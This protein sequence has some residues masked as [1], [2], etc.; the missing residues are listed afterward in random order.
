M[1]RLLL[2][3]MTIGFA[4]ACAQ[5]PQKSEQKTPIGGPCEGCEAAY[6]YG[7]KHLSPT[8]SLPGFGEKGE[9]LMVIGTVY[10]QD[11]TTPAEGTILY[12]YHTD[13]EGLYSHPHP[14]VAQGWENRHGYYR[15][16]IKT[17]ADGKYTFYTFRPAAYPT[18]TEAAHI[19]LTVLEPGKNPYWVDSYVFEGDPLL[20]PEFR[21]RYTGRGGS[22]ILHLEKQGD[23]WVGKRDLVLGEGIPDY[24]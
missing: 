4:T 13:L 12:V 7:D 11:G 20:T 19:H 8:D 5:T 16:W 17:G 9:K 18:G 1:S 10:Q 22:G 15:G 2:L 3:L 23:L 14:E 24:R 21:K 6:E